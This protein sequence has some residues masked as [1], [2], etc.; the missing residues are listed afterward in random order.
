MTVEPGELATLLCTRERMVQEL[1]SGLN[2][3][4]RGF[5]FSL[6]AARPAWPLLGIAHAERLPGIQ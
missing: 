6:V 4:E 3:D 5:L 2:A 1:Q